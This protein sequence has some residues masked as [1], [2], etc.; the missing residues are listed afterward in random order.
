MLD[1]LLR[2][3]I[4]LLLQPMATLALMLGMRPNHVTLCGFFIGAL[5]VLAIIVGEPY[6]GA[7][8]LLLNRVAD[9]MDGLMAKI[10]GRTDFGGFLDISCDF[11]IYTGFIWAH[12]YA[13]PEYSLWLIFLLFSFVGPTISFLVYMMLEAKQSRR[14]MSTSKRS[15]AALTSVGEG[16]ETMFVLFL[17]CLFP[18]CIPM[19]SLGY[20]IVCWLVTISRFIVCWKR[21]GAY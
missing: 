13:H 1:S 16:T 21:F 11:I 8:F 3:Y 9:G 2:P 15:F 12:A 18:E 10:S 6:W 5:S 19:A 17:M 20:G 14:V 4:N 7:F